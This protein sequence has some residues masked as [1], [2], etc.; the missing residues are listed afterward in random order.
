MSKTIDGVRHFVCKKCGQK[1]QEGIAHWKKKSQKDK[2][3]CLDCIKRRKIMEQTREEMGLS[4]GS[5]FG[6]YR[7]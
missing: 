1:K 6:R 2:N 7:M 4:I 3:V 5:F